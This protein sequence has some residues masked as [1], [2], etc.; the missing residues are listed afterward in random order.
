MMRDDIVGWLL[1]VVLI[2]SSLIPKS[3]QNW[4]F[5][6]FGMYRYFIIVPMFGVILAMLWSDARPLVPIMTLI[7]IVAIYWDWRTMQK[8]KK[9]AK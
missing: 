8:I 5:I 2:I 1:P 9:D 7:S 3:Y 4:I 6:K